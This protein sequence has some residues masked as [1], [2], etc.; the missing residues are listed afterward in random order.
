MWQFVGEETCLL[1][2]KMPHL[3]VPRAHLICKYL[4]LYLFLS[5]DYKVIENNHC[6]LQKQNLNLKCLAQIIV[7]SLVIN[8]Y[9]LVSE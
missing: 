8:K 9:L 6:L 4:F 5:L 7:L 2:S 3:C 1:L